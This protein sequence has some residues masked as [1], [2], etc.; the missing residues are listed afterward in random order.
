VTRSIQQILMAALLRL[1]QSPDMSPEEVERVRKLAM[2]M[3]TD[4]T[5][6]KSDRSEEPVAA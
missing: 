2:R 1:E 5:L 3:M 4:V 6:A